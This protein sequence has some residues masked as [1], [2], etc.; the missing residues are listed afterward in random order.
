VTAVANDVSF[1]DVFVRQIIALANKGDA[2]IAISTS[3]N[4][5]NL[6]RAFHTARQLQLFTIGFAGDDG[7]RMKQMR[8]QGLIDF[9]LTVP[10]SSIHRIQE[11]HVM[12]Y[13]IIWDVVHEFLQH[14]VLLSSAESGVRSLESGST[15]E[16]ADARLQTSDSRPQV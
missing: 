5:D 9:C 2:L 4:S 11:T 1:A 14:P 15:L 12:L 6:L 8:A 16:T 13:H 3:G 10:T 7:G